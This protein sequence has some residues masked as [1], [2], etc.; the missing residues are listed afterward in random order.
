[1]PGALGTILGLLQHHMLS[2]YL[3]VDVHEPVGGVVHLLGR[4]KPPLLLQQ[5]QDNLQGDFV[6]A[7]SITI[8]RWIEG[9]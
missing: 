3:A 1:M 4:R 2:I 6:D 9:I 8:L 7:W 5:A